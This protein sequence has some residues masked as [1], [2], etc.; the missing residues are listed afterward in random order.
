MVSKHKY[1]IYKIGEAYKV[2]IVDY[3]TSDIKSDLTLLPYGLDVQL[4]F[5]FYLLSCSFIFDVLIV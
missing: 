5:Y 2:L 1:F 3:K 4:P